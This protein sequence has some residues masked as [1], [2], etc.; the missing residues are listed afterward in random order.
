MVLLDVNILWFFLSTSLVV[1]MQA[2]AV[3]L[4]ATNRQLAASE[5][6]LRGENGEL[7]S[8]NQQL[9]ELGAAKSEL[10]ANV[11]YEILAPLRSILTAAEMARGDCQDPILTSRCLTTVVSECEN[12]EKIV[13]SLPTNDEVERRGLWWLEA[14]VD[15]ASV[16]RIAAATMGPVAHRTGV[17][18]DVD[19]PDEL[20][21]VW[22]DH[23]RL[24]HVVDVLLDNAIMLS[25]Q[26]GRVELVAK[27]TGPEV[28][29]SVAQC[30]GSTRAFDPGVFDAGIADRP[31][32]EREN[33]TPT[34]RMLW[35]RMCKEV[36]E[37]RHGRIWVEQH[38]SGGS[39]FKIAFSHGSYEGR[40][41]VYAG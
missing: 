36:V 33:A 5:V 16:V 41:V 38:E 39:I 31:A 25:R 29:I 12:L 26:G 32:H 1:L 7:G 10:L 24:V 35:L 40:D 18:V 3:R 4:A 8:A 27:T 13:Q 34:G 14:R 30:S 23:D 17:Q 21:T 20:P 6:A 9:A 15:I 19:C 2:Q 11:E 22:A 37:N 28:L